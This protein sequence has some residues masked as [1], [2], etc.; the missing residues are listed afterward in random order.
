MSTS[1]PLKSLADHT[2]TRPDLPA[3]FPVKISETD[4]HPSPPPSRLPSLAY[5]EKL[6]GRVS[7]KDHLPVSTVRC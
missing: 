4:H 1:L 2:E 5:L 3:I 7:V 6:S